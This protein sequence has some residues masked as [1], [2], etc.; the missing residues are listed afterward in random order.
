MTDTDVEVIEVTVVTEPVEVVVVDAASGALAEVLAEKAR[1]EAAEDDLQTQIDAVEVG[2]GKNPL[3][4][5][6]HVDGYGAD[7]TGV[8]NADAA[9]TAAMSAVNLAGGTV[10]CDGTYKLSADVIAIANDNVKIVATAGTQFNVSGAGRGIHYDDSAIRRRC[11][12]EN[13]R[14]SMLT[15]GAIAYSL[16]NAYRS[17][18]KDCKFE[19]QAGTTGIGVDFDGDI[20]T[21][22][23]LNEFYGCDAWGSLDSVRM[24]NNVNGNRWYGGTLEGPGRAVH[25]R[26]PVSNMG[27]NIFIGVAIQSA[28]TNS[29][30]EL[31]R[32]GDAGDVGQCA[33]NTFADCRFETTGATTIYVGALG[34]YNSFIG[35]SMA[36]SVTFDLHNTSSPQTD[37]LVL[38]NNGS[39][40][41]IAVYDMNVDHLDATGAVKAGSLEADPSSATTVKIDA[42]K[43]SA[44]GTGSDQNLKL[45]AKGNGLV[46]VNADAFDPDDGV[47]VYTGGATPK[48]IA[49]I[50]NAQVPFASF[51]YASHDHYQAWKSTDSVPR[52]AVAYDG[53]VEF[54]SGSGARDTNLYRSAADTLKTDDTLIVGTP[55]TAAGSA[56]TVDGTQTLTNKSLTSPVSTGTPTVP[57]AAQG[58]NT[59]Q[60]AST[61]YVQTELAVDPAWIAPTLVNSWVNYGS[62]EQVAGYRLRNG[63][64]EIRGGVKSGSVNPIFVLPAGYRPAADHTFVVSSDPGLATVYVQ[65]SGSVYLAGYAAG[66][67][68]AFVSLAGI[69]FSRL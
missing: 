15:A 12:V 26:A 46:T 57:T 11:G 22:T 67:T 48:D 24:G 68:N 36:G 64:V 49:Y 45:A 54:G 3:T 30:G 42:G 39:G 50:A 40:V 23:Y 65:A 6:F 20:T 59:T 32:L 9:F 31:I 60:A 63:H 41:P 47:I 52:W 14:V 53:G 16:A 8:T 17:V 4:G 1:A 18:N 10:W 35:G 28:G 13:I 69:S 21:S 25:M 7:P 27:T 55:G 37:P 2:V 34:W 19:S 58:T 43:I 38:M 62:A 61:A 51:L 29:S 5:W 56:V 44:A 66:G 33:Y